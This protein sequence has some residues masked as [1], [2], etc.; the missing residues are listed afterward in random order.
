MERT[1]NNI[2]EMW[3]VRFSLKKLTIL[4][5]KRV[6]SMVLSEPWIKAEQSHQRNT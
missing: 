6:E 2:D 5:S 3:L 1:K 4:K